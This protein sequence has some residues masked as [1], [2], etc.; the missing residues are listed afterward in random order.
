MPIERDPVQ[1]DSLADVA[2]LSRSANRV[3]IL[4]A[5]TRGPSARRE[6][7]EETDTSRT[8]L[9][10][11]VNELE[12][13]GWAERRND[14]DYEATATGERLMTEM[15]PFLESVQALRRLGDAVTWLPEDL[16]IGLHH[17]ADA[18][19]RR[20][21]GDDPIETVDYFV[22][23]ARDASEITVLT[24]LAAPIP[25]ARTMRDR[26]TAGELTAD[27][28][29]TGSLVDYLGDASEHR[30]VWR[31]ILGAGTGVY[32]YDG[33]IP[34]NL[35]VFG[36]TVLVKKSRPG[37]IHESYGVPIVTEDETVRTWALDLVEQYRAEATRV[38]VERF[39][40]EQPVSQV[41]SGDG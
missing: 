1:T 27:Y 7:A 13:R 17:F 25:L 21:E 20:P 38:G 24:H 14:G 10:R 15:R 8:T 11:I 39:T 31:D 34:C 19:V 41:E 12:E 37:P 18:T 26:L 3:R 28:V 35:Y 16:S 33:H 5:L 2:Y 4:D 40:D 9:D 30:S 29:I 32:R 36:E 6:L 23:L 22:D